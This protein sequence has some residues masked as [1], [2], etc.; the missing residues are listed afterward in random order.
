[1]VMT[2]MPVAAASSTTFGEPSRQ[3]GRHQVHRAVIRLC[4]SYK[5][6]AMNARMGFYHGMQIGTE[7]VFCGIEPAH[8]QQV[9]SRSDSRM[10]SKASINSGSPLSKVNRPTKPTT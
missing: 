4:I 8:K 1:M 5:P 3:V 9:R 2:G 7:R 10:V 6:G